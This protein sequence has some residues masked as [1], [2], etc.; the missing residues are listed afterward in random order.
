MK[1]KMFEI[2]NPSAGCAMTDMTYDVDWAGSC[3]IQRDTRFMDP[4]AIDLPGRIRLS[5]RLCKIRG[6]IVIRPGYRAKAWHSFRGPALQPL[7]FSHSEQT[8][9]FVHTV[10][11]CLNKRK[12]SQI[13][14]D[15]HIVSYFYSLI[16]ISA[17]VRNF[18]Q[19][20]QFTYWR[21]VTD[22]NW[23]EF[24]IANRKTLAAAKAPNWILWTG[25]ALSIFMGLR[26]WHHLFYF[27]YLCE[28][29]YKKK[30]INV[31]K[32]KVLPRRCHH[33]SN[34]QAVQARRLHTNFPSHSSE[35]TPKGTTN[36]EVGSYL[37]LIDFN[38]S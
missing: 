21:W 11:I 35:P 9:W 24:E 14:L 31:R 32:K 20:S 38:W 23:G 33:H 34:V 15:L 26:S 22:F 8:K 13:R 10:F 19:T 18:V 3:I 5:S 29:S 36:R 4:L 17:N 12:G 27:F 16:S 1:W 37:S 2:A 6:K 28:K 7:L 25:L 30:F